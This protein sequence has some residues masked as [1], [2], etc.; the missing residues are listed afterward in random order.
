MIEEGISKNLNKQTDLI[1]SDLLI[2]F[3]ENKYKISVRDPQGILS[4][5]QEW[6]L[7]ESDTIWNLMLINST[8]LDSCKSVNILTHSDIYTIV[9]AE[10]YREENKKDFLAQLCL[11]NNSLP[12]IA[13][14]IKSSDAY[15][16]YQPSITLFKLLKECPAQTKLFHHAGIFIEYEQERNRSDFN[17]VFIHFETNVFNCIVFKDKQLV[18]SNNQNFYSASDA[19][20]FLLAIFQRINIDPNEQIVV[21][22]GEVMPYSDLYNT[23]YRFIKNVEWFNVSVDPKI[24]YMENTSSPH[25]FSDL[26][27]LSACV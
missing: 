23:I 10:L 19:V 7:R 3:T 4:L 12:V 8:D 2:A 25:L 26:I 27:R 11:I 1:N 21:L 17:E 5:F 9:P 13:Q 22:S 15:I 18:Y 14:T 6:D 16:I 24:K 20:Y